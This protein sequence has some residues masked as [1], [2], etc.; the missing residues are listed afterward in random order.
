MNTARFPNLEQLERQAYS[1]L[2]NDGLIDLTAGIALFT[3]GVAW[4]TGNSPYSPF[5]APML[6]PVWMVARKKI[7]EPRIGVVNLG[8]DR[9]KK[10]KRNLLFLFMFGVL[11]FVMGLALYFLG[12]LRETLAANNQANWVAGLPAALLAAPAVIVAISF[13][14][15]RYFIYAAALLMAALPVAV[16][17]Q[18]PGWAFIPAGVLFI[19][20]G[21]H[22]LIQFLRDYPL[23]S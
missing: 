3:I 4:V 14:V 13:D 7:S 12:P 11:T 21:G 17:D 10:G 6:I 19:V 16:L 22:M 23:D 18:H 2:W 5:V 9:V 15:K 8:A 1:T 20:T